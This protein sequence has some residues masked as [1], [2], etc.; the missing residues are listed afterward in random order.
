MAQIDD[1]LRKL[2]TERA[3]GLCEYC[4]A[5]QLIVVYMEIDHIIPRSQ[6]GSSEPDNLCFSC[7]G[8]NGY[9]QD[10]V[11]GI[12][13]QTNTEHPLFNPRTQAWNDHF[14][15]A[16]DGIL[17]KAKTAVGRVTIERLRMNRDDVLSAR[18]LWVQAG[19]HPPIR[20][21]FPTR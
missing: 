1:A 3:A 10:Y 2:V 20:G 17:L 11:S 16:D 14:E 7:R 6:G 12:D 15:W 13:A 8:C 9:K 18:N 5:A 21:R 4:Q 19:W